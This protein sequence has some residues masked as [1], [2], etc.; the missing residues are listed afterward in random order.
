MS[1]LF[2][3][4]LTVRFRGRTSFEA[5]TRK[6]YSF[7]MDR[8]AI[9]NRVKELRDE[10]EFLVRQN[11]AYEVYSI[12]NIRDQRMKL[13]GVVTRNQYSHYLRLYASRGAV[14]RDGVQAGLNQPRPHLEVIP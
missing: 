5:K 9:L 12:H 13:T 6:P 1:S 8:D 7:C 3:G 10:I 14:L 4:V 2:C 11:Q